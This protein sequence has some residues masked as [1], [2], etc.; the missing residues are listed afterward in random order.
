MRPPSMNNPKRVSEKAKNRPK[1]RIQSGLPQTHTKSKFR[2]A[3]KADYNQ[4]VGNAGA[5]KKRNQS[6]GI[7]LPYRLTP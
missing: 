4:V 6:A 5:H 2:K 3:E 7:S 1:F